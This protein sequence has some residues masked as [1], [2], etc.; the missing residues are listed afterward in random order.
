MVTKTDLRMLDGT[1]VTGGSISADGV[2]TLTFSDGTTKALQGAIGSSGSDGAQ[3]PVGPMGPAGPQ[4]PKGDTGDVGPQGPAGTPFT[5]EA[6]A[7]GG[8]SGWTRFPNG[9]ILQWGRNYVTRLA[10]TTIYYPIAFPNACFGV[11]NTLITYGSNVG[12]DNNDVVMSVTAANFVMRT[13][14]NNGGYWFAYGN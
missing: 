2:L 12:A 9:L 1:V 3:G 7:L 4:G 10:N 11:M 13:D 8:D 6:G 5:M 14:N